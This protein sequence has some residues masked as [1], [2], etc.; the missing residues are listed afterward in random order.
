[1]GEVDDGFVLRVGAKASEAFRPAIIVA[2]HCCEVEKRSSQLAHN[3]QIGSSN[4]PFATKYDS[5][6][7]CGKDGD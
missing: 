3:Q 6:A 1:M 2:N 5:P 4:L 7:P